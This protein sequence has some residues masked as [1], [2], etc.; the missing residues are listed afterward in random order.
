MVGYFDN[1]ATTYKKP[2]G[3]YDYIKEY[4]L[5]NGV[6]I[7]RGSYAAS[8]N[9]GSLLHKTRT[10]LLLLM[11]APETK[12]VVFTPSATIALNTILYGLNFNKGD[13]VYISHFE[14]NAILR[15][16]YDLEK[17][18]GIKIKFLPMQKEDKYS[19]DTEEIEKR[20]K[21]EKPKAVILSN[22]SNVLGIIAPIKEISRIAK[23]NGVITIVDGAQACGLID[24]NL[25]FIDYYVFAGHKT[26]LGPTGIGGFICDRNTQLS[27][28][29]HGGTG[30]DSANR[31]M[32]IS[33][34][35]RFEAGS[36]NL[37]SIAGL[38]FS[39][40][41]IYEN[42]AF[43]KKSERDNLNLLYDILK[44]YDFIKIISPFPRVSSIISCY[45]D[46]YTSDEFGLVLAEKG[47]A[48]RT[49]LHC[50]PEAHKYIGSFPEGLIR[51]SI[52]CF[53]NKD[54]FDIL[55]TVL[56]DIATEL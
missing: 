37:M 32:P 11:N 3:M 40:S 13:M 51:F 43:V 33:V 52:S 4:M 6:N 35:E 19:F 42:M 7:G 26:L 54:D 12:T 55:K 23:E 45:V 15:P 18:I 38:N 56:D 5:S 17:R 49:G 27:P 48:V 31:E 1:A 21:L 36:M 16:L 28:L 2:D 25:S 53:T 34:P 22:V 8:L 50:A 44:R 39:L 46:G 47:I 24:C 10:K 30:I 20:I 14:H 9:G 41:W 29:I